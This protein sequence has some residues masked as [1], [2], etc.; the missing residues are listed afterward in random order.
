MGFNTQ[1]FFDKT[2][3]FY[4]NNIYLLV[5]VYKYMKYSNIKKQ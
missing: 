1:V 5:N 2:L 3:L 4:K